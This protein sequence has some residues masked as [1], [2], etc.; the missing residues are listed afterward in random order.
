M[1]IKKIVNMNFPV[2]SSRAKLWNVYKMY[3][4]YYWIPTL[5]SLILFDSSRVKHRIILLVLFFK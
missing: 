5:S 3:M 4:Q 2:S 1:E